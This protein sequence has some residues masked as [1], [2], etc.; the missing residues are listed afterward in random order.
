MPE[1]RQEKLDRTANLMPAQLRASGLL[2]GFADPRLFFKTFGWFKWQKKH[3]LTEAE[4]E[5]FQKIFTEACN[6][7]AAL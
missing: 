4:T 7:S 3:E 1:T 2:A 6:D 5:R